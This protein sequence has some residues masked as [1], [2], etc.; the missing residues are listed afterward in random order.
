[1]MNIPLLIAILVGI[2]SYIAYICANVDKF[3]PL[4]YEDETGF[5]YGI[6]SRPKY[7]DEDEDED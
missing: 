3:F 7:K 1:M 5:H 6:E 4:G 2:V